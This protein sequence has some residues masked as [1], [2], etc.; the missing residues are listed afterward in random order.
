[1]VAAA[2]AH[3]LCTLAVVLGNYHRSCLSNALSLAGALLVY[4]LANYSLTHMNLPQM[5]KARLAH[6]RKFMST[7]DYL[8]REQHESQVPRV[9]RCTWLD[10]QK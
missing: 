8:H 2:V 5:I 3:S 6:P 7:P 10:G 4:A 9:A 1:M